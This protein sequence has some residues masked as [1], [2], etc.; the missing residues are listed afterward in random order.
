MAKTARLHRADRSSILLGTILIIFINK[1]FLPKIMPPVNIY[2]TKNR[3]GS[4]RSILKDLRAYI[5]KELSCGERGLNP[6]EISLRIIPTS[7]SSLQIADTELDIFA[8]SYPERV[9]KQDEICLSIKKYIEGNCPR[10]GSVYVWLPLSEL[11][12]SA[13][14]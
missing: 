6:L 1:E 12:H 3:I 7:G 8:Y 5:A 10:A 11:G 2:T 9:K 13:R 4:L 14:D